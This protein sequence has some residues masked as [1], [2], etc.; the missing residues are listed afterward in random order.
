M[1]IPCE[2][3]FDTLGLAATV[4]APRAE[5]A[6]ETTVIWVPPSSV[7]VPT[8]ADLTRKTPIRILA[9]K[10]AEVT[11]IPI[12][13]LIEVAELSDED[14]KIWR[15]EEFDRVEADI[16]RVVVVEV[17]EGCDA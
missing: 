11:D 9:L 6:V 17:L 10:R 15:V 3:L 5:R 8:A 7:D 12:G 1:T 14:V 2:E 4:T 16:V 13:T